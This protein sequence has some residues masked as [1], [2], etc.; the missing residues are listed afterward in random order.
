MKQ[1]YYAVLGLTR[2]ASAEDIQ[3]T[4]RTLALRHHPD[5]NA[6]PDAA[7]RMS[8]INEAY[9]V[10]GEPERRR[11]YDRRMAQPGPGTELAAAILQAARDLALRSGWRL[12]EDNTRD[13][14]LESGRTRVRLVFIERLDEGALHRAAREF[15]EPVVVLAVAAD[16][17]MEAPAGAAR[18]AAAVIDLMRGRR[19]GRAFPADFEAACKTLLSPFL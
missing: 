10:L 7:A 16:F 15:P 19:F 3:R 17:R 13:M 4:Y 6:A 5:R 18:A 9:A 14:L 1:D 12:V 8:A 11:E 2:K